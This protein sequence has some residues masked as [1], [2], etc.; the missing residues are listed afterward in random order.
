MGRL[1]EKSGQHW[2]SFRYFWL[3]GRGWQGRVERAEAEEVCRAGLGRASLLLVSGEFGLCPE[4]KGE[5]RSPFFFKI[6]IVAW[7]LI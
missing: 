3:E 4:S 7:I 6:R 5:H 2:E 1:Q